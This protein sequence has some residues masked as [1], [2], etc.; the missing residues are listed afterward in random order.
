MLMVF[1]AAADFPTVAQEF[2]KAPLVMLAKGAELADLSELA[3]LAGGDK[4]MGSVFEG[5]DIAVGRAGAAGRSSLRKT[6]GI[7][8]MLNPSLA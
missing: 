3:I 8:I 5:I 4:R 7:E 6:R 1:D 2:A